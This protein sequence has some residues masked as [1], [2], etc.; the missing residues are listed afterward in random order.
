M[1]FKGECWKQASLGWMGCVISWRRR[2][3]PWVWAT[4]SLSAFFS[5]GQK[6]YRYACK[7]NLNQRSD[8][9][10]LT[11]N[12]NQAVMKCLEPGRVLQPQGNVWVLGSTYGELYIQDPQIAGHMRGREGPGERL[13]SCLCKNVGRTK[14]IKFFKE[15]ECDLICLFIWHIWN[16]S[17]QIILV[18][19][20]LSFSL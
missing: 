12:G 2:R 7:F 18:I 3:R 14:E 19:I 4:D 1:D 10:S 16:G 15:V 8:R 6:N 5:V 11:W 17:Y 13:D 20:I 9:V